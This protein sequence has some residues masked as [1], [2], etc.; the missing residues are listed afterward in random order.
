MVF[1]PA[2]EEMDERGHVIYG[3]TSF[4]DYVARYGIETSGR[5]PRYISVDAL[6]ELSPEL[7][8]ADVMVLRMGSASEGTGTQF[9]LV[10]ALEDL[11][12]FFLVDEAIFS[13]D[14]PSEYDPPI[15]SEKLL[16]FQLLPTLSETSL[17]NL[18]LASGLLCD[19]LELDTTGSLMPPATGRSTFS[20]DV[21][22]HSSVIETYEHRT[23]Q[24]EVDTLFAEKRDGE[25][26]LF[27]IEAKTGTDRPTLAKHKLV[28]PALAMADSVP[29]EIEIVPLYLRCTQADGRMTFKIVECDLHD[30]REE[31][32]G[33]D[34]LEASQSHTAQLNLDVL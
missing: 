22:P 28:Y 12:E 15:E 9:L 13:R 21:R 29:P 10:Q 2:L 1:E 16:S 8:A 25:T 6:R 32:P 18:A 20:F 23:G 4:R 27:V 17:I 19:V 14:E 3:P 33:V 24:V 26:V 34:E 11:E 7:R 5:T 30:P 31:L